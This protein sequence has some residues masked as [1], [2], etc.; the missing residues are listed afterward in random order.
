MI[1]WIRTWGGEGEE[2]E[3]AFDEQVQERLPPPRQEREHLEGSY[4][5]LIDLSSV[6]RFDFICLG[7]RV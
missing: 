1:K 4:F 3:E 6:Q 7:S 2:G 5:R